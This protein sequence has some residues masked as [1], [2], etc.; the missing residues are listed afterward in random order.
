MQRFV[1]EYRS[2]R[3]GGPLERVIVA[4]FDDTKIQRWYG[5]GQARRKQGTNV[6]R[7]AHRGRW[8]V[9]R[10]YTEE[11]P[12]YELITPDQ[13]RSWLRNNGHHGAANQYFGRGQAVAAGSGVGNQL[14]A[15]LRARLD[16]RAT[17]QGTSRAALIRTAIEGLL[18]T[19]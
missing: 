7:T 16:E 2:V 12:L 11:D 8:L 3:P 13:A 5:T 10:W 18:A 1:F 9:E 15:D 17:A 14:P 4:R 19:G 6:I